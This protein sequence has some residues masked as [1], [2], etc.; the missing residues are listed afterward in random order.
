MIVDLENNSIPQ[1][2]TRY[3]LSSFIIDQSGHRLGPQ[4]ITNILAENPAAASR[5]PNSMPSMTGS[6]SA[7]NG[8]SR[9]TFVLNGHHSGTRNHAMR[10]HWAERQKARKEKK[11]QQTRRRALP[12]LAKEG[13]VSSASSS[14]SQGT[15][16]FAVTVQESPATEQVA[17]VD[18]VET[19]QSGIPGVP[20]QL[21]TGVN[22]ALASTRLDPF[23]SFPIRLTGQHHKL[24]HHCTVYQPANRELNQV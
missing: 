11:R 6:P 15:N 7:E 13:L 21:L 4:T 17:D 18:N 20:A 2:L 14:E 5:F 22:H 24:I 12:I 16:A 9:F 19:G 3:A 1:A 23:D 8:G 10:A